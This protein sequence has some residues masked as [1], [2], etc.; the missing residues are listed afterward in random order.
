M[1]PDLQVYST[2]VVVVWFYFLEKL[3]NL[4]IGGCL[5][6]GDVTAEHLGLGPVEQDEDT[7]A[8]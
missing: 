5:L 1:S 2:C 8:S 3:S 7:V 6:A 4:G